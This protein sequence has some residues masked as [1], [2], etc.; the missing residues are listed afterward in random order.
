[1]F[2]FTHP[3]RGATFVS[4]DLFEIALVS[5]H[6]PR[7]GCDDAEA[8]SLSGIIVSIH[9]PRAGC[10]TVCLN[11]SALITKFQ[12]THPV[13]GATHV[14]INQRMISKCFNSRTPCGVRLSCLVAT[15]CQNHVSIHAPRAGCD[16]D[17]EYCSSTV[18]RFNSRTPC[19]VRRCL[20]FSF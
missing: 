7:A 13:R 14:I 4:N 9:A 11:L 19:G 15:A 10:D 17:S 18:L 3:V 20:I 16:A 6:A 1:M 12:F 2:Q 5:I 8:S